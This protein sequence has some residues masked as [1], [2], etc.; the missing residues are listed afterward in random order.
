MISQEEQRKVST[1]LMVE[2]QEKAK[3]EA[4]ELSPG[5]GCRAEGLGSQVWV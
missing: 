2:A 3:E 5:L 4:G 1:K